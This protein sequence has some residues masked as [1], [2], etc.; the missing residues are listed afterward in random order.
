MLITSFVYKSRT[1]LKFRSMDKDKI[2]TAAAGRFATVGEA[3]SLESLSKGAVY[4][5]RELLPLAKETLRKNL[6]MSLRSATG[7]KRQLSRSPV[8]GGCTSTRKR[9]YN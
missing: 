3:R 7:T 9:R 6:P 8:L 2:T 1:H 5:I 4:E